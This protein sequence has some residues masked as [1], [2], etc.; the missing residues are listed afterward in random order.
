MNKDTIIQTTT[1]EVDKNEPVLINNKAVITFNNFTLNNFKLETD[2]I[3]FNIITSN[4][5]NFD[6]SY[7]Y[8]VLSKGN[9]DIITLK[10]I[11]ENKGETELTLLF[12]K[13]LENT[14]DINGTI[15]EIKKEDYPKVTLSS[16]EAGFATLLCKNSD[17]TIEYLFSNNNLINIIDVYTYIDRNNGEYLN[18]FQKY[19]NL[20]NELNSLGAISN[21]IEDSMKFVMTTNIDLNNYQYDNNKN[22]NYYSLNTEP[23]II[24]FEMEAKGFDCE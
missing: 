7:Y 9:K 22:I 24:N 16:D 11:G 14:L 6:K 8:L 23:K 15:K 18:M 20:S 1:K 17:N 13:T 5:I 21:I 10:L 3:T 4:N 12:N 19:S 2:K